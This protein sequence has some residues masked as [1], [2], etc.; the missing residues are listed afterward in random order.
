MCM[1]QAISD[2]LMAIGL[3]LEG[4]NVAPTA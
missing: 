1:P 3:E 2:Y 4:K